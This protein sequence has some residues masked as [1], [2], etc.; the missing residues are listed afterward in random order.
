MSGSRPGGPLLSAL[1]CAAC[2]GPK[3]DL[4]PPRPGELRSEIDVV[5]HDRHT[6]VVERAGAAFL[7]WGYAEKAWYVENRRGLSGAMRA[8]FWPTASALGCEQRDFPLWRRH[9]EEE[10]ERWSFVVSRR[11]LEELHAYL[12][13]ERGPP[14][15]NLPGWNE[16]AHAYHLFH[17]CHHVTA[18]ALRAA[19]LP[20]APWWCLTGGLIRLQLNRIRRFQ[21]SEGERPGR[22]SA[23]VP[24]TRTA[25]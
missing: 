7:E 14:L 23:E 10:V 15:P 3:P 16:G 4:W 17:Q 22:A 9:P 2:V 21:D 25:R 20:I 24:A 19:G 13:S 5:F 11:G 8:L 18:G 1:L 6:V 12:E